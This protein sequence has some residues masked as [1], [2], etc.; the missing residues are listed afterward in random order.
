MKAC[1]R[2]LERLTY[3]AIGGILTAS[4]CILFLNSPY[5]RSE[6][7]D[8]YLKFL[9]AL[10][11]VLVGLAIVSAALHTILSQRNR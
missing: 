3:I 2:G 8:A 9:F 10:S 4:V 7:T 11:A 5:S 1:L 6:T